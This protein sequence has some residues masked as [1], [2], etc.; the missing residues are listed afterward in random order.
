[1]I[2]IINKTINF[3]RNKFSDIYNNVKNYFLDKLNDDRKYKNLLFGLFAAASIITV[4]IFSIGLVLFSFGVQGYGELGD[5]VGGNINPL[6]TFIT[7]MGLIISIVMQREELIATRMELSTSSQALVQQHEVLERQAFETTFFQLIKLYQDY[8]L[9]LSFSR[10]DEHQGAGAVKLLYGKLD[11]EATYIITVCAEENNIN[12]MRSKI[13]EHFLSVF[14]SESVLTNHV[15]GLYRRFSSILIY[16]GSSK[17][18][19]FYVHNVLMPQLS[20]YELYMLYYSCFVYG[21]ESLLDVIDHIGVFKDIKI[22]G[23]I[24]EQ[25]TMLYNHMLHRS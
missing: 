5:F 14:N 25:N 7:F 24:I 21:E 20:D 18:G 9:N 22:S 15:E 17:F 8:V 11:K 19:S 6:L 13:K 12:L 2:K 3:L 16:V 10:S 1:M 4:S 23:L